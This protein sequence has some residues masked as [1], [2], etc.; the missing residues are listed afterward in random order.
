MRCNLYICLL[1]GEW[2]LN[3]DQRP[4]LMIDHDDGAMPWVNN[5][6]A[7]G[8]QLIWPKRIFPK[9]AAQPLAH[10][11]EHLAKLVH[12]RTRAVS[13][14]GVTRLDVHEFGGV[15]IEEQRAQ[16]AVLAELE[17][18]HLVHLRPSTHPD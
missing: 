4:P 18:Q 17:V 13:P 6:R 2:S 5:P 9:V 8:P 12:A 15:H 7:D 10:T 1:R 11:H 3:D 16:I 14:E